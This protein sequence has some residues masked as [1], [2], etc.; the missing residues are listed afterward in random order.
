MKILLCLFL[1]SVGVLRAHDHVYVGLDPKNPQQLYLLSPSDQ[2]A[3]YVPRGARFTVPRFP[4]GCFACELSFTTGLMNADPL[5]EITSV[6]GPLGGSFSFW[7]ADALGP[8]WS[9]TTGWTLGQGTAPSF[10]VI[11]FGEY[12]QHGRVFSMDTPGI[13]SVN[14][15]AVDADGVLTPSEEK[16][17]TFQALPPPQLSIRMENGQVVIS[18]LSRLDFLYDLQIST[19]LTFDRWDSVVA[20][21][22]EGDGTVK[23]TSL[24]LEQPRAFFRLVEF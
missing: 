12:H 1:L 21:F 7:E 5:I 8:T 18:F 15:R 20:G 4:G 13:Y 17:I 9:R 3:L 10:P 14:F 2:E 23:E 16:I 11:Y 24:K 22:I 19:D 6:L